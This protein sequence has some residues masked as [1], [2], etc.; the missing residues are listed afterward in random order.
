L[1]KW[2]IALLHGCVVISLLLRMKSAE[3]SVTSKLKE[4]RPIILWPWTVGMI[5]VWYS[6]HG[7]GRRKT[8]TKSFQPFPCH[9]IQQLLPQSSSDFLHHGLVDHISLSSMHSILD[10]EATRIFH[11]NPPVICYLSWLL[12]WQH[13]GL[14]FSPFSS[15]PMLRTPRGQSRLCRSW[16]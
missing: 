8:T 7:T 2:C 3:S 6:S 12:S 9:Y 4:Y 16:Q 15:T 11:A 13:L 5:S 1:F 10:H 14:C